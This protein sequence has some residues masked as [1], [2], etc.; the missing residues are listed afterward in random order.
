MRNHSLPEN[1][2]ACGS[3][4]TEKDELGFG[5]EWRALNIHKAL[6]FLHIVMTG[7]ESDLF[8]MY[9]WNLLYTIISAMFS[10]DFLHFLVVHTVY[11]LRECRYPRKIYLEILV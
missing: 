10:L 7:K 9:S 6:F 8:T 5:I 4:S 2:A 11:A 1:M 3:A